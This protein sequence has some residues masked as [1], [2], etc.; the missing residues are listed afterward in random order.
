MSS[1][2]TRN[3]ARLSL[4]PIFNSSAAGRRRRSMLPPLA[5]RPSRVRPLRAAISSASLSTQRS[6]PRVRRRNASASTLS[7]SSNA[8]TVPGLGSS[9][10]RRAAL[11]SASLTP[12]T[13]RPPLSA[14]YS[15]TARSSSAAGTSNAS[16]LPRR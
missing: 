4:A 8:A 14:R 7:P 6:S 9:P 5:S 10:L 15:F 3:R 13:L 1:R 12:Y 11:D 2:S 16:T